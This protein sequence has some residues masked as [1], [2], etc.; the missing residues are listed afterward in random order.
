MIRFNPDAYKDENEQSH[1]S[2]PMQHVHVAFDKKQHQ[3]L[4]PSKGDI[5]VG[6]MLRAAGGRSATMK[7]AKRRL[8]AVGGINAY[9]E[10]LTDPNHIREL[11]QAAALAESLSEINRTG[12]GKYLL[13][14]YDEKWFW[15]L[16]L[17]AKAK[18]CKELGVEKKSFNMFHKNH[19]DKVMCLAITGYAYENNIENGG[20]GLKLGFYRCEAAKIAKRT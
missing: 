3:I 12:N 4:Q 7:L 17:R 2:G 1:P 9:C 14:H 6:E 10:K 20:I 16:V 19:I 15:A 13:V 18:A 11:Q 8:N 5:T